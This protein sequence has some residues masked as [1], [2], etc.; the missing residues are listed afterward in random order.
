[1]VTVTRA[2]GRRRTRSADRR[3]ALID[4]ALAVFI[5]KGVSGASVDDVVTTAGVAKGTF[6]LY[7]GSKDE[8]ISA[9]AERM[10][11]AVGDAVEAAAATG[12]GSAFE[13][14][15]ALGGAMAQV[16]HTAH[17]RDLLEFIHR[18]ENRTVHEQMSDRIMA[19]LAPTLAGIIGDGVAE[20]SFRPQDPD[21][22]ANFVLGAFSRLHDLVTAP[23][24]LPAALAELNAFVLRGLG[25][26][27]VA[28]P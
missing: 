24:E 2:G 22:A 13:R 19:R 9:V 4:A 16:G 10:V 25:R 6:Y 12:Q 27:G 15:L 3:S 1:M 8:V 20:G 11:A 5:A 14:V 21:L 23:E 26:N 7:F 17:E 28:P 18:P